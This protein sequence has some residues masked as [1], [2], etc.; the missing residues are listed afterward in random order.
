MCYEARAV[1]EAHADP[2]SCQCEVSAHQQT[3]GGAST[4]LCKATP[5]RS[6]SYSFVFKWGFGNK[7]VGTH[8][9]HS[10]VGRCYSLLHQVEH[11]ALDQMECTPLPL[12]PLPVCIA[13]LLLFCCCLQQACQSL[14]PYTSSF[15]SKG[16]CVHFHN[17]ECVCV[18]DMGT[19]NGSG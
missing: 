7:D 12:L 16:S 8:L 15:F 19:C 9:A 11:P 4:A 2:G 18:C 5:W 3:S 10:Q 17:H 6:M 13:L 1:A 14:R